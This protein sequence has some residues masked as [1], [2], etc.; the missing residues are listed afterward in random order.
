MSA[1]ALPQAAAGVSDGTSANIAYNMNTAD[2]RA[3]ADAG[4]LGQIQA[5]TDAG[6]AG[7]LKL[8]AAQSDL[9]RLDINS[10]ASRSVLPYALQPSQMA[11]ANARDLAAGKRTMAGNKLGGQVGL[12]KSNVE[13]SRNVGKLYADTI[14]KAL[15]NYYQQR[16]TSESDYAGGMTG[17]SQRY[18]DV[19]RNL[20]DRA[21]SSVK[22]NSDL[23][24][25]M[26]GFAP[27]LNGISTSWGDIASTAKSGVKTINDY[28]V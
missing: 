25:V 1:V 4:R 24:D 5:Y 26:S 28:F 10:D 19:N 3:T 6:R 23:G 17:A 15:T 9:S 22:T 12:T 14:D 21:I 11:Y 16:L 2:S 20:T 7:N 8:N 13:G 18:E 27:A